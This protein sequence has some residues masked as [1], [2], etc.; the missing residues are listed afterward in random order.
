M[1][2]SLYYLKNLIKISKLKGV[3]YFLKWDF[4]I[5]IKYIA[6]KKWFYLIKIIF[7]KNV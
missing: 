4:Y 5:L 6:L 3:S 2:F 7:K 1:K